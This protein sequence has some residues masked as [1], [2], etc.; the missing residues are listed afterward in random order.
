MA[1]KF[2][3]KKMRRPPNAP[4]QPLTA[5]VSDAFLLVYYQA[6]V[7]RLANAV[8]QVPRG[9]EKSENDH[10]G[11]NR[12]LHRLLRGM[13]KPQAEHVAP[14]HKSHGDFQHGLV[15]EVYWPG[16]CPGYPKGGPCLRCPLE[17]PNLGDNGDA[18]QRADCR[19]CH[20][21]AATVQAV[22][23][24]V[25]LQKAEVSADQQDKLHGN[26]L[27]LG[28][29]S[30]GVALSWSAMLAHDELR[31]GHAP[32]VHRETKDRGRF[33]EVHRTPGG[34]RVDH[35]IHHSRPQRRGPAGHQEESDVPLRQSVKKVPESWG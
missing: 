9:V 34:N 23:V 33:D 8:F 29:D 24:R 15:Q 1:L 4:R 7:V 18:V 17:T 10:G 6:A 31:E 28:K 5:D 35:G 11:Q 13:G 19:E 21:A 16:C 32:E 12:W 25:K 26:G 20:E 3:L 14:Q 30:Q 2:N 22:V 27:G